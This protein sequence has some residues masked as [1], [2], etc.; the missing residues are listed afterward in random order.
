VNQADS[1]NL[2][3]QMMACHVRERG[4]GPNQDNQRIQGAVFEQLFEFVP[5]DAVAAMIRRHEDDI[6]IIAA[7][8][9]RQLYLLEVFPEQ[10]SMQQPETEC[11]LIHVKPGTATL[12]VRTRYF[13]GTGTVP[14]RRTTWRFEFSGGPTLTIETQL[15]PDG[16]IEPSEALARAL[17]AV[18]GWKMDL[19]ARA[20]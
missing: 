2:A 3:R 5:E 16:E 8:H 4:P 15:D 7:I 11:R 1:A 9:D 17:A 13:Q 12:R 6:P 14:A 10:D 18:L 20:G 19:P